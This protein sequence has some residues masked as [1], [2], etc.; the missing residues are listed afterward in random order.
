MSDLPTVGQ[1][2]GGEGTPTSTRA[3]LKTTTTSVRKPASAKTPAPAK[4]SSA[5]AGKPATQAAGKP[6][7]QS[8]GKR[9]AQTATA[10]VS[11]TL[12]TVADRALSTAAGQLAAAPA[13][14]TG[15]VSQPRPA[16]PDAAPLA[17]EIG[18]TMA[19]LFGGLQQTTAPQDRLPTEH[20]LAPPQRIEVEVER[21]NALL[22]RLGKLLGPGP[23]QPSPGPDQPS[24]GPAQPSPG[25]AQ[26]SPGPAQSAVPVQSAV[27]AVGPITGAVDDTTHAWKPDESSQGS[28]GETNL[29]ILTW[30]AR[31]DR[32]LSIAY[33]LGRSLRDTA[34]PPQRAPSDAGAPP[35]TSEDALKNQLSRARVAR[36]QEWLSTL[37]LRLPAD[38]AAVVS[39]SMGRWC[40][41]TSTI[42]LPNTPGKLTAR[43]PSASD[44]ATG[45]HASLAPQGDT[46][47]NLLVG[48]ESAEAL[49]TPEGLVAAGEAA[50]RRT[51]RI[52]RKILAHYWFALLVL[53]IA[54]GVVLYLTAADLSGAGK[55]WTEIAAVAGTLGVTAKGVGSTMARLSRS[56][57]KPIFGLERVDA[58]AWAVTAIPGGLKLNTRGVRALRSSGIRPPGPLGRV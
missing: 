8:A 52:I 34:H 24:P 25:P 1:D 36:L 20:E 39:A 30:L 56:A 50:L 7:T 33:Q 51:A 11:E 19:L 42:F 26:P 44:V 55:V 18:W 22:G 13:E 53:A 45:L 40:D 31:T 6:A 28:L 29:K 15:P 58:M 41:L 47:L 2:S 46:W 5:D 10:D 12:F 38:S 21:V 37:A 35:T 3:G 32:D 16:P 4:A 9:G 14:D 48:T 54:L 27:P 43:S 17:V 49:L 57:E 23:A